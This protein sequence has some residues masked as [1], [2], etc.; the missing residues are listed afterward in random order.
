VDLQQ[1]R[2]QAKDLVRAAR[3]DD[4]EAL[5][6]LAGRE[7][8]LAAAQLVVARE[9]G[10]VSWP[11]LIAAAEAGGDAVVLAATSGRPERART[12]LD[13]EPALLE[14]PWVRLV[15]G[16]RWDGDVARPGG[17][18]RWPPLVYVAHSALAGVD[19]LEDLLRRGADPNASGPGEYGPVSALYG[20]S[21][22]VR[23][24]ER[25]RA[26]LEAGATPDDEDSLYHAAESA[27]TTCLRLLLAHGARTSDTSALAHALDYDA[28]EP[29]RVLL[30]AGADANEGALV[31]HA[32]RRGRGPEAIE[33]LAARGADLDRPGGETWRGDVPLRTPYQHAVLRANDGVAA[34]LRRLGADTRVSAAD[35][36]VAALAR[37]VAPAQPLPARLDVDQQEVL[38]LAALG[39]HLDAVV[40][41]VGVEFAGVVGGSPSGTLLHHAS[42]VGA[43]EAVRALLARGADP[44]AGADVAMP[45]PLGWA[46]GGSV[47]HRVPGRDYVA[48]ADALVAAGDTITPAHVEAADGPLHAW[49]A[50]RV[51]R[52]AGG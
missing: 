11:A 9:Q 35:A 12:R 30:D 41:A 5:A 19:A 3:R 18:R 27:D 20:A 47:Y 24:P 45:T 48:V 34:T 13:A 1:L 25:T 2:K 36:G 21:G 22:V 37:G 4:P 6:R 17:P 23:D 49:L 42:W 28:L 26:L 46:A 40:D 44:L 29:V 16:R 50:A 8:K 14:D 7:V 32:V 31:A 52:G 38:V 51:E 39:G 33:L 10:Y 15:L 43:P